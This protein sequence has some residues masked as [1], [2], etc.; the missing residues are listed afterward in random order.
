MTNQK[1]WQ[2][3]LIERLLTEATPH[4]QGTQVP[5]MTPAIECAVVLRG[6][7]TPI[8]GA[9]ST[10]PEGGLRLLSPTGAPPA[11]ARQGPDA[12]VKRML[13]VEQFF[14]YE[15]ILVVGLMREMQLT[16]PLIHTA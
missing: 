12:G 1:P 8:H 2:Q 13:F 6:Y 4:P 9:L 11:S 16:A 10:T 3:T 5:G 15:D 14:A 7:P